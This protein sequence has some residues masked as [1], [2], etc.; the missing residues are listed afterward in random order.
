MLCCGLI[1]IKSHG[2]KVYTFRF[3]TGWANIY[4]IIIIIIIISLLLLLF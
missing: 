4:I 2:L 1:I 3:E